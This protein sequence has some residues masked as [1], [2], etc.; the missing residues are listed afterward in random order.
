MIESLKQVGQE[1][2]TL[3]SLPPSTAVEVA[4]VTCESSNLEH[5]H[6]MRKK[7]LPILKTQKGFLAWRAFQSKTTEGVMM[8]LL[9]WEQVE[10]CH[11]AGKNLQNTE[12][13]KEFFGLMKQT[14]VFELFERQAI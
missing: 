10:D 7:M 4:I 5:Y 2:L 12:T 8:D 13:G 11:E 3:E 9:Y 6:E 14:L 1:L